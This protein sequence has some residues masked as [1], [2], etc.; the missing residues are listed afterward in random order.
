MKTRYYFFSAFILLFQFNVFSTEIPK[1][2]SRTE[3]PW[4]EGGII[5]QKTMLDSIK[6]IGADVIRL[7]LSRDQ[8]KENVKNHIL[9]CNKIRLKVMVMIKVGNIKEIYPAGTELRNGQGRFWDVYKHSDIDTAL[10][11]NWIYGVL[12]YW[13]DAGCVIDQIE[14]GNE[15]AWCDFNGDFPIV[16]QGTGFA[17]DYSFNWGDL[18][19]EVRIGLSKMG[20]LMKSTKKAIDQIYLNN[21]PELVLGGLNWYTD[22]SWMISKGGTIMM[23]EYALRI[24]KGTAPGQPLSHNYLKYID[25]IAIHP[26][27][28][29]QYNENKQSMIEASENYINSFM[30][31]IDTVTN[32]PVY[33]T[34]FGYKISVNGGAGDEKRAAMFDSFFTSLENNPKYIWKGIYIYSWDQG[35]HRITENFRTMYSARHIFTKQNDTTTSVISITNKST[36]NILPSFTTINRGDIIE[37]KNSENKEYLLHLVT[38]SGLNIYSHLIN[39]KLY[40]PYYINRGLYLLVLEDIVS[41]IKDVKKIIIM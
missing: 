37:L 13:N 15:F 5:F 41:K 3:L 12:K 18:P 25:A 22:Q 19:T 35:E 17:Y 27:P 36:N 9:H 8:L 23:P 38:L 4:L 20:V 16:A 34:E 40:I 2:I 1:G 7:S 32:L 24:L 6:N 10:Y 21:I 14:I 31:R 29:N 11:A 28:N 39:E 26:Y 33:L 30:N